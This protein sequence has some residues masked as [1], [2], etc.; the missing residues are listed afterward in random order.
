MPGLPVREITVLSARDDQAA[1]VEMIRLTRLWPGYDTVALYEGERA[2]A[3]ASNPHLG[4][5]EHPL[6]WEFVAA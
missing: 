5:P 6:E 1:E 3:V 4:F 2:V